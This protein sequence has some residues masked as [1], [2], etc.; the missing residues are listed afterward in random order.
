MFT[1]YFPI[2]PFRLVP[3]FSG[4]TPTTP[5]ISI[6]SH[7]ESSWAW[8]YSYV[9]DTEI[10]FGL[11]PRSPDVR[12]TRRMPLV[13][14]E[15]STLSEHLSSPPVF[16][17]VRVT[18]SLVL[19]VMLCR[20]LVVLFLLAIVL[21]VLRLTDSD[22]SFGIFKLFLN[23]RL[24]ICNQWLSPLMFSCWTVALMVFFWP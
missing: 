18:R 8:S 16:I 5:F 9:V 4:V 11:W 21:S 1:Y 20:S 12:V 2:H 7:E 15:L 17:E 22:Y 3:M 14:Q 13:A 19:C 10:Y 24:H 6:Y 23:L